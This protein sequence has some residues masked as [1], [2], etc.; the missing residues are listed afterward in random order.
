MLRRAGGAMSRAGRDRPPPTSSRREGCARM[1]STIMG[2]SASA[3]LTGAVAVHLVQS[4]FVI[5]LR[6]VQT[7]WPPFHRDE[8]RRAP[9]RSVRGRPA[10]ADMVKRRLAPA[11][12]EASTDHGTRRAYRRALAISPRPITVPRP[13]TGRHGA[14]VEARGPRQELRGARRCRGPPLRNPDRRRRRSRP[15]V[16]EAGL[17]ANKDQT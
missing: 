14:A 8:A 13:T 3:A 1:T 10:R 7:F 9:T 2:I 5:P 11:M 12:E 4:A 6:V 16:R 15:P 17:R